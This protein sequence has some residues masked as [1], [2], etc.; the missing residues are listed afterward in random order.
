MNSKSKVT[1]NSR[2]SFNRLLAAGVG[3]MLLCL[4]PAPATAQTY[5]VLHTFGTNVM[6]LNPRAPLVQGPDGAVYGTTEQGGSANRGQVFKVNPDGSGY[7]VL[8]DFTGSDGAY[9]DGGLVMSGRTLYGTTAMARLEFGGRFEGNG[10]VFAI[11]IDGTGFTNLHLFLG[12]PSDGANPSAGLI[13]SGNTLYGTT[14]YGGNSDSGTVFTLNTDGTG[15]ATLYQFTATDPATGT[16]SD[17]AGPQDGLTLSA[18]TLYGTAEGGGTSGGGTV[19]AVN[20]DGSGFTVLREFSSSDGASPQGSLVLSGTM[21]Y[22]TT[23][24]GGSNGNGTVFAINAD[25]SDFTVLKDFTNSTDGESPNAGLVLSGTTLYGTCAWGGGLGYGNLFMV[26]RDGSG[27]AV[28]KDFT[29]SNGGANMYGRLMVSGTNLFG[30]TCHGGNSGCGTV[31]RVE[32]DGSGYAVIQNFEQGDGAYPCPNLTLSGTTL[33]GTTAY[34]GAFGNGVIFREEADGSGYAVLKNFTNS[35]DGVAPSAGL[36]CSNST[37][38]GTCYG[39]GLGMG[40]VFRVNTDG[41]GFCVIETFTNWIEAAY[42]NSSLVLS[43]STL[44]GTTAGGGADN[45]G[46]VFKVNTDG[47]GYTVLKAFRYRSDGAYPDGLVLS[48]TTLYGAASYGGGYDNG[49]VFRVNT[50]GS[51]FVVLKHFEG[52]IQGGNMA[53]PVGCLVLSGTTLYGT[54][55]Q[56]GSHDQGTVFKINTDGSGYTVLYNFSAVVGTGSNSTSADGAYPNGSLLLVGKTLYGTTIQGGNDDYGTVFTI[57]TNGGDFAVLKVFSVNDGA[58]PFPRAGLVLSGA[59]LYG[60]TGG[61]GSLGS[62]VLFSLSLLPTII[63]SPQTQTAEAG[64]TVQVTVQA[65]GQPPLAYQWYFN[66]TNMLSCTDSYL[67]LTN[68]PSP[69]SG[70]Y[71]VVVTNQFGAVTSAPA[72][73]NVIAPVARRLVPG[74]NLMAQPGNFLGLDYR[75]NLGPTANWA[76]MATIV[77]SNSSQFY[78]DVSEPLPPKRFYRAW[79]TGSPSVVPS[80]RLPGMVPAITLT[81]NIGHSVRLDYINQFGPIDAWVTLATVTLTNTSQLYFDTSSI[82][83]PARLWRIVPVP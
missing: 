22:G 68:I 61:G 23:S 54:T 81:G 74:V 10:T 83:Q 40:T 45:C 35:L 67:V 70:A 44:Y 41:S 79:Q 3:M 33:Y 24:G 1:N 26:K 28:L 71:T 6:G 47:T 19:F 55:A 50:D 77:L 8:R 11:N 82:G 78:F 69:Q 66:G 75:D 31:F 16:N 49:T 43:G 42:P 64:T 65:A 56:G 59:S 21:L 14:V 73:L 39:G 7:T 9:P 32:T 13:L 29:N 62:G 18:N 46:T 76:T 80:L 30:T 52:V 17:G 27:F 36:V 12:Y 53:G 48:G 63:T 2:Q 25:G 5:T 57:N 20:T 34:G 72:K 15:Y 51:G 37:L 38:Y 60:T 4:A 58:Y